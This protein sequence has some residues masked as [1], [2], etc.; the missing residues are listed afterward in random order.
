M[1]IFLASVSGADDSADKSSPVEME[2]SVSA[3]FEKIKKDPI[4]LR[5][6]LYRFPK[7]GDLH[8]HLDGSIY[9]ESY[10]KWAAEDGRCIDMSTVSILTSPCDENAGNVP[11]SSIFSNE[12]IYQ[13]AVDAM[14]VRNIEFGSISGHDQFFSTFRKFSKAIPGREGEMLAEVANRAARQNTHYLELI[15]V[16]GI[17]EASSLRHGVSHQY[18]DDDLKTLVDG[19]E[20]DEIAGQV[21]SLTDRAEAKMRDILQCQTKSPKPGCS[22]EIRYLPA[23]I[24]VFPRTALISQ[25]AI[26]F[27][28]VARDS[29]YVGVN[30][31]AP[32]DSRI[33]L[34]DYDW[35]MQ[36][37]QDMA[38]QFSTP[39]PRTLHAGELDLGLVPP[40][41][42][43]DHISKAVHK[44][45]ARRIGHG[46]SIGFE[47]DYPVLLETMKNQGILV[48]IN[49]TSNEIILGVQGKRHPFLSYLNA[50]VPMSL[51]TD[52][53]GVSRID[54]THEYQ[55]AVE[56]YNIGYATLKSLSRNALEYSF[57]P[58]ESLFT[59]PRHFQRVDACK[60]MESRVCKKFISPSEKARLQRQLEERF[61]RFEQSLAF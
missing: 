26:A 33:A 44:A 42:L 25:A 21:I 61:L 56:T 12:Q 27:S 11:V 49:L 10:L 31:V 36:L 40:E 24:R 28:L 57:L 37:L 46:V 59:E 45:G 3:Y 1:L 15:V 51:S 50:G 4:S 23:M 39:I 2:A 34:Q 7:G 48:E 8:N 43:K 19:K 20:I 30:L 52:D 58:G 55:K 22:V 5:H 16:F 60:Q 53:E 17:L 14:S 18:T 13:G 54:L 35:Q 29:R 41:A 9:A 32:E 6:F 47:N 38:N